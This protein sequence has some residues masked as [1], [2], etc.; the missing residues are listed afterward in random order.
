MRTLDAQTTRAIV[1]GGECL[2]AKCEEDHELGYELLKRIA[3]NLG[4]RLD[5]LRYQ[6]LDLYGTDAVTT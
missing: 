6:L 5:G 2:R 3:A 1:L 4:Q